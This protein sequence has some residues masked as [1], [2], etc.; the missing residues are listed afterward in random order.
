METT[1]YIA[2]SRQ[3][4]LRRHM[5]VV[6]NNIANTTVS[7]FKAESLALDPV[8]VDSGAGERLAFVQD[9]A[10]LRD[11]RPGPMT[12]TGNPLDLAI[13]GEGYFVV[14]TGAGPRY[15]RGGQ[16]RL[17]ELGELVTTDGHPVLDD[18]GATLALPPGGGPITVAADGTISSGSSVVGRVGI[19][20]FP[21]QH[22]LEKVGGGLFRTDQ[23]PVPVEDARVVQGALEGSNVNPI[24]EMTEMMATL[25]AYQGTQRLLETHHEL[26]RRA[27][28]HMLEVTG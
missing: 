7:G 14:E 17:D 2:L 16:F 13:E 18:G 12:R 10:V 19:V 25:R 24:L 28:E 26:Q 15:G 6:A 11:F 27:I 4:A 21:D 20:T 22:R 9:V 1:A 23:A 8:P 3:M 5:E